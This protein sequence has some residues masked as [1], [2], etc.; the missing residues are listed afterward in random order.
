MKRRR[1]RPLCMY[2]YREVHT[3]H[4]L[5][6]ALFSSFQNPRLGR[7][8]TCS[9]LC[10]AREVPSA[11]GASID[12]PCNEARRARSTPFAALCLMTAPPVSGRA[13]VP[14]PPSEHRSK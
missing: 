12:R 11:G 13:P 2:R 9:V 7:D 14:P 6:W 1:R 10:I 3:C 4:G 8:A 5:W